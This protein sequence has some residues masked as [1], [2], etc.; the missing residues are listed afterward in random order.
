VLEVHHTS[1][2]H[3]ETPV[4]LLNRMTTIFKAKTNKVADAA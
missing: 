2:N 1:H 3:K 4:S